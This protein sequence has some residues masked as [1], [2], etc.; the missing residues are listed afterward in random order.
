MHKYATPVANEHH[1]VPSQSSEESVGQRGLFHL[2]G[3]RRHIGADTEGKH[4][5]ARRLQHV[6]RKGR[7]LPG[8]AHRGT[9]LGNEGARLADH[10]GAGE[11]HREDAEVGHVA[12]KVHLIRRHE[13]AD[14]AERADVDDDR[15]VDEGEGWG[16]GGEARDEVAKKHEEGDLT[17]QQIDE[18]EAVDC[19]ETAEHGLVVNGPIDQN[20]VRVS[21]ESRG[22]QQN[23]PG[24]EE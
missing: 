19:R 3:D 6:P 13:G 1:D 18:K 14:N 10:D 22:A 16:E 23:Y 4:D 9:L 20:P 12:H 17:C 7:R 15:P 8:V 2:H 21:L 5:D 11:E 24:G